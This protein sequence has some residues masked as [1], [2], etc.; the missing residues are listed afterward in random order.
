MTVLGSAGRWTKQVGNTILAAE[1][2]RIQGMTVRTVVCVQKEW[3]ADDT[4]K[5]QTR[6]KIEGTKKSRKREEIEE[7]R[8]ALTIDIIKQEWA[9]RFVFLIF[10]LHR[11][12][13][14]VRLCQAVSQGS[15]GGGS[16]RA[17]WRTA[18]L[19]HSR[20]WN[21]QQVSSGKYPRMDTCNSRIHADQNANNGAR[22]DEHC[23]G[24][25]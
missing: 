1:D 2:T 23:V 5:S 4:N 17:P 9:V 20:P 6:E 18:G 24:C 8:R 3:T 7:R 25:Q 12:R 16:P 22:N 19:T 10:G 21:A 14:P 15:N 13:R 11:E